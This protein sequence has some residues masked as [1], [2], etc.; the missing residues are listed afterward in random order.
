M[1]EEYFDV[2]DL[3]PAK[4]G[5]QGI[6]WSNHFDHMQT[7]GEGLILYPPNERAAR[8]QRSSAFSMAKYKGLKASSRLVKDS[9][10]YTLYIW[11]V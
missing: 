3:P 6:P 5:R 9:T 7:T 4:R 2:K 11:L 1:K 10:G 8:I